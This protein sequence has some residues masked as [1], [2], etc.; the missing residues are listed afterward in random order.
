[1]L[2]IAYPNKGFNDAYNE[3]FS[4]KKQL[5]GLPDDQIITSRESLVWKIYA[6]KTKEDDKKNE[7]STPKKSPMKINQTSNIP[8]QR[9]ETQKPLPIGKSNF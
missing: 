8:L 5:F 2:E 6:K 7:S 1:M 4:N 3:Y 9:N